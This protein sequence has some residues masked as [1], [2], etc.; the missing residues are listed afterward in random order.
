MITV[1]QIYNEVEKLVNEYPEAIYKGHCNYITGKV[2]NGPKEEGCI[3]GQAIRRLDPGFDFGCRDGSPIGHL[4]NSSILNFE[5][6]STEKLIKL[7][8]TQIHQDAGHNW[9]ISFLRAQK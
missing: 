1:S 4:V 5:N 3:I 8:D 7:I 9:R 2:E 6:D